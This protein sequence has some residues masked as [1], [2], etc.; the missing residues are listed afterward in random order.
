[1]D[2]FVGEI[3]GSFSQILKC[4][5]EFS[6]AQEVKYIFL[7]IYSNYFYLSQGRNSH[8]IYIYNFA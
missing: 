6:S 7:L 5:S 4:F 2:E 8:K 1:M 3:G